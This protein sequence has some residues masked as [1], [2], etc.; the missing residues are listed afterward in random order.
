MVSPSTLAAN[1]AQYSNALAAH[2]TSP[3]DSRRVFPS[4]RV[5]SL[6]SCSELS[7]TRLVSLERRRP[8]LL[9]SMSIQPADSSAVFAL[10]TAAFASCFV[11]RGT[12]PPTPCF[13]RA[14]NDE[15]APL[16]PSL[17]SPPTLLLYFFILTV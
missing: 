15:T 14:R 16:L 13:A 11:A 6:A 3:F 4:L 9:G 7:R 8:L 12:S 5:S 1:P 10:S 2:A 17:P